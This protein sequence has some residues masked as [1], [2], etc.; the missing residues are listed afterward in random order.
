MKC[1]SKMCITPLVAVVGLSTA[2]MASGSPIYVSEYDSNKDRFISKGKEFNA[3]ALAINPVPLAALD[4]DKDGYVSDSENEGFAELKR[5]RV[6]SLMVDLGDKQIYSF[7][8]LA[9]RGPN[10][11]TH[12]SEQDSEPEPE[13]EKKEEWA[14]YLRSS[15]ED[16]GTLKA[17]LP[18]AK[19]SPALFSFARSYAD[20]ESAWSAVGTLMGIKKVADYPIA[21]EDGGLSA[22]YLIP[23][24]SFNK[25]DTNGNAAKEVDSLI[26]RFGTEA[27]FLG[28]QKAAFV[29][30]NPT[31]ATD[32]DFRSLVGGFEFQFEPYVNG[33]VIGSAQSHFNGGLQYLLRPMLNV[34]AGCV[35]D[36]G[37]KA[38]LQDHEDNFFTRVGPQLHLDM[39]SDIPWLER[40]SL[41]LSYSHLEALGNGVESG[42]FFDSSLSY[43]LD[44]EGNIMLT[45]KYQHGEVPF[46]QDSVDT[47]TV[48]LGVKF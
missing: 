34:E 8:E 26:F 6:E 46:I 12:R 15:R 42:G 27:V 9:A 3:F 18:V 2:A 28:D 24:L 25:I 5:Q 17:A 10:I 11:F 45:T 38:N 37:R 20:G 31:F 7:A 44:K 43:R 32:T 29:R 47:I 39:W 1:H 41:T 13:P 35:F 14:W 22:I 4:P 23:S 16:I 19:A 30:A 36:A 48:G 33:S 40:F 21:D